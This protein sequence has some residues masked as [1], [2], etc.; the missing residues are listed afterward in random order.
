MLGDEPLR[1]AELGEVSEAAMPGA[2]EVGYSTPAMAGA[3]IFVE[4]DGD[5]LYVGS[6]GAA[7]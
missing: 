3:L 1:D 6:S 4:L 7:T 2:V 5:W